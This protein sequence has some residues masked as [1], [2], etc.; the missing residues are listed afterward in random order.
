MCAIN[1]VKSLPKEYLTKVT[2][3]FSDGDKWCNTDASLFTIR[4]FWRDFFPCVKDG[5]DYFFF[6]D[7]IFLNDFSLE[8]C[9]QIVNHFQRCVFRVEIFKTTHVV[10]F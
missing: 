8:S 6:Y 9:V 4:E 10:I 7:S 1:K 5:W 3:I 2:L